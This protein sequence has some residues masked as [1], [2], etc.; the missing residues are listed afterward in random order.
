[1]CLATFLDTGVVIGYCFLLD[2]HHRNCRA[3]VQRDLD[4]ELFVSDTVENEY[5]HAKRNVSRRLANG[6]RK[7]VRAI[8]RDE[9]EDELGPVELNRLQNEVLDSTNEAYQ[10]LYR[11]YD[12]GVGNFVNQSELCTRLRTMAREIESF[13]LERKQELD[14][15]VTVWQCENSYDG[16]EA[17]LSMIPE[18]DRQICIEAHDLASARSPRTVFAT[19]NPRDFVDDGIAETILAV[20]EIDDVENLAVGS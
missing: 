17:S 14:S 4:R 9:C 5:D 10:F 6:V 1:M 12:D 11:F 7:H 20:T 16:I 19:V 18:Q 8:K 2:D 3:F 15:K 13:P